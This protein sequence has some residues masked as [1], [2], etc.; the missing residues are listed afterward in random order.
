MSNQ[1]PQRSESVLKSP[2]FLVAIVSG[3]VT[4]VAAFIGVLPSLVVNSP[5]ATVT[6]SPAPTVQITH[7]PIPSPV[8]ELI[9][10]EAPQ[11]AQ[12]TLIE[13]LRTPDGVTTTQSD[14]PISD[15]NT[16]PNTRLIYDAVS[17]NV[18][19]QSGG[20]LSLVGVT[21]RS[22]SGTW[23]ARSWGPSIYT[24]LPN[25]KCLRLRDASAGQR[26]PPQ[27]CINQIY[28]LIEV[29]KPAMF[30][31]NSDTFEVIRDNQTL[32]TCKITDGMCDIYIA[33]A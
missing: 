6:P 13:L 19:N 30:W 25:A 24:S 22:T 2:Q 23:D 32:A 27:P 11:P 26:N 14:S 20:T 29:G 17:F 15:G 18:V 28:G 7:T 1:P 8:T 33:P 4:I 3:L 10:T 12:P 16:Q 21:F 31:V 9:S 5:T